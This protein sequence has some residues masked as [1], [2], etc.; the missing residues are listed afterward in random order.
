MSTPQPQLMH[1]PTG[2][3]TQP[4]MA[5]PVLMTAPELEGLQAEL[6]TLRRRSREEMAQRLRDARSY[7]NSSNNDEYYALRE[8]QMVIEARIASLADA[9]RRAT[10]VGQEVAAEGVAVIGS[11][12]SVEDLDSGNVSQ[13]RLAGA[14]Q[15]LQRG[16]ISAA[17]PMGQALL[18]AAPG[19]VVTVDLPNGR[20]RSVRLVAVESD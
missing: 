7:G 2:P 4:P 8:E 5:S 14:H 16:A 13:Y 1:T 18:G 20:S 11:T 3:A 17:S 9:V 19:T 12:M 15:A 10:V 6:E